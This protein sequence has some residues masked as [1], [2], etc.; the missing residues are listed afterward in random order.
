MHNRCQRWNRLLLFFQS[1]PGQKCCKVLR[2]GSDVRVLASFIR[3]AERV[4]VKGLIWR[5]TG[6]RPMLLVSGPC[7]RFNGMGC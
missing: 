6:C 4:G 2:I 1:E 7:N 3:E 5:F